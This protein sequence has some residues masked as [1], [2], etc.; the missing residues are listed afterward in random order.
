MLVLAG[1]QLLPG[2]E[3]IT[4]P[5][6]GQSATES[7]PVRVQKGLDYSSRDDVAA[8]LHA[9]QELPPNYIS[10]AE[11]QKLGWNSAQG[12]LWESCPGKSIGGDPFGNREGLLPAAS[13]R[14][15]YECDINYNGG[16]RGGERI[17]YSND[18]L[19]YY[20][21]DHYQTFTRLYEEASP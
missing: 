14:Q 13:G 6:P 2:D 16:Y 15:Y 20:T 10:K 8:Y 18:G 4:E 11:A 7:S 19:I 3:P 12:N 9:Y 21:G 1:C 5:P 17:V